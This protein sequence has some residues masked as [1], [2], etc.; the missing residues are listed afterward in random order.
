MT[1]ANAI[2]TLPQISGKV[3]D[4]QLLLFR[5]IYLLTKNH[6]NPIIKYKIIAPEIIIA[7]LL[8][9]LFS[10]DKMII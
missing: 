8:F 4:V 3:Q 1:I 6:R 10:I 7:N 2:L 5:L 9:E